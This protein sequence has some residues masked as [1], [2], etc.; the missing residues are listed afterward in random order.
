MTLLKRLFQNPTDTRS[1][2][3]KRLQDVIRQDRVEAPSAL[4]R[5]AQQNFSRGFATQS[6]SPQNSPFI[7]V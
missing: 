1:V 5:R 7:R 6:R 4:A 2:A 3:Q